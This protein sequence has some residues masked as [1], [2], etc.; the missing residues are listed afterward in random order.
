MKNAF[1]TNGDYNV[2]LVDWGGGSSLP[3][4]QATANTRVVGALIAKLIKYLQVIL[5]L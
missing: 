5:N 1:L 2:V 3:Y 4:T